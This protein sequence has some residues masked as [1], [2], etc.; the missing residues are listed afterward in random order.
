LIQPG[1]PFYSPLNTVDPAKLVVGVAYDATNWGMQ[2][3]GTGVRRHTLLSDPTFFRPGG[4]GTLDFYA[5]YAPARNV[6]LY[7]GAT[8]LA[9]RK[10]WD[11]GNLNGGLLGN[12]VS[13]NGVNDAGT[14][15]IPAD[16][17]TMPGRAFSVAARI[18]F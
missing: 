13:G 14:N 11:W 10:Y 17:L 18:T 5:H 6:T 12:L 1:D 4:Y 16:R 2:L 9:D 3:V 8:N 7:F 15:G